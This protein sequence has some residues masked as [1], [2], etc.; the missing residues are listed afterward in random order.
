MSTPTPP[1]QPPVVTW[2][3]K[4]TD[5]SNE[6]EFFYVLDRVSGEVRVPV[7]QKDGKVVT[8]IVT[9]GPANK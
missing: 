8:Y 3:C 1:P 4:V 6:Q 9:C 7:R 2:V 5:T